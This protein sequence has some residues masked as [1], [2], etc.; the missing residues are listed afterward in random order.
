M[1]LKEKNAKTAE[2]WFNLG[3]KAKEPEKKVE[4]YTKALEIDPKNA[5]AW[6][7]KGDAL[8]DLDKYED[9][10]HCYNKARE[11]KPQPSHVWLRKA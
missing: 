1:G 8:Y 4:Y 3:S 11:I 7:N 9:A 10:I 2:E 6:N 5:D